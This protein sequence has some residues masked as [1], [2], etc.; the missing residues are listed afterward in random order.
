M[1]YAG[2]GDI[3]AFTAWWGTR[4]YTLATVGTNLI[5][6]RRDSDNTE[7]DFASVAGGGLD[8]TAIAAFKSAGSPD[9]N[10]NLFVTKF[11]D[12][13]GTQHFLQ[14]TSSGQPSFEL[15]GKGLLPTVRFSAHNLEITSFTQAQPFSLSGFALYNGPGQSSLICSTGGGA[16]Q[17]LYGFVAQDAVSMYALGNIQATATDN[18]WHAV[19]ALFNSVSSKAAA[20]GT[21]TAGNGGTGA[22]SGQLYLGFD[23]A[24]PFKGNFMEIG[25]L[26][27]DQSASFSAL[28]TNQHTYYDQTGYT[29]PGDAVSASAYAWWSTRAYKQANIGSFAIR[30]RESGGDTEKDFT[31]VTGGGLDLTAIA[32]FKGANNLFVTKIYSQIGYINATHLVQATHGN[33]P[34]FVLNG[35]G[36]LPVIAFALPQDMSANVN[37]ISQPYTFSVVYKTDASATGA[38]GYYFVGNG[39]QYQILSNNGNQL[40]LYAGSYQTFTQ[41]V[42]TYYA[43]QAVFDGA[44]SNA[45]IDG[46]SNPCSPGTD[47]SSNLVVYGSLS[48]GGSFIG[49]SMELG[50]FASALS[51]GDAITLTTS[52]H[53]YWGFGQTPGAGSSTGAGAAAAIGQAT[54]FLRPDADSVQGTWTNESAGTQLWSHI[55]E[56]VPDDSD[57]IRSAE[58]PSSDT[59]RV[60]LSDPS[61]GVATPVAVSYRYGRRGSGPINLTVT[62]KQGTTTIASWSHSAISATPVT[63]RQTLSGG[64]LASITDYSDLRLEFTAIGYVGPGDITSFT[65]FWGSRA[66]SAATIGVNA[67]R[68]RES[69]GDTEQDFATIAGGGLDLTTIAT[70]KGANSL[71]A[72]KVYDQVGT[73]HMVQ[74]THANQPEFKL[75]VLGTLPAIYFG[76]GNWYMATT[77]NHSEPQPLSF[78]FVYNRTSVAADGLF[79]SS[80]SGLIQ[81]IRT[82]AIG[83]GANIANMGFISGLVAAT[84]AADHSWHAI[85]ALGYG[86]SSNLTVNGSATLGDAGPYGLSAETIQFGYPALAFAGYGMEMG[87]K[88]SDISTNFAALNSNQH[89]YYNSG[90]DSATDAWTAVV[91][92]N[93]GTVSAARKTL[94]DNLIVGLKADGV[95]TKLDRLWLHA[96]ENAPSALTDLVTNTLA[97]TVNSPTFTTDRGYTGNG[98]TQYINLHYNQSTNGVNFTTNSASGF[99]YQRTQ[100]TAA[101][102]ITFGSYNACVM[103]MGNGGALQACNIVDG[104]FSTITPANGIVVL[105]R[106]GASVRNF[107]NNGSNVLSDTQAA[108]G[109]LNAD[110]YILGDGSVGYSSAQVASCGFGGGLSSTEQ[111]S[112]STRI[113]TYMTA[114]GANVY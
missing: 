55:D 98:S 91:V 15:G 88:S 7:Q 27:G 22:F 74:A 68:L 26:N 114:I 80:L 58:N 47:V 112:L 44:S 66:Y 62:L 50:W 70:F 13:V 38:G 51:S 99:L 9:L 24:N 63:A 100:D 35:I 64:Q 103:I 39:G 85:G 8:L 2:P 71:F 60:T 53:T 52:Q 28:S 83:G 59:C 37:G 107:Y 11:Y 102:H 5:R 54:A 82:S 110:M 57:Y 111:A 45:Y 20:D 76:G 75:S 36:S 25:V 86:A 49:N 16:T 30:L 97:T 95:W 72:V 77:N 104:S 46:V 96:A 56:V 92:A 41:S 69:G 40:I 105:S 101:F 1:S 61:T 67:I 89:S 14:A 84:A 10:V 87:F 106:T 18:N 32:A 4:A 81:I 42:G 29:G 21:S 12:Q 65:A 73:D 113:N 48:S 43:L 23:S 79:A 109:S 6:L 94:V 31:F 78:S 33:Q 90:F 19:A 34:S 3:V 108:A 17:L 93:G